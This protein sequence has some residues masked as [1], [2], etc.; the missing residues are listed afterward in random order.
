M[1]LK[2]FRVFFIGL[3][4]V[5]CDK[6]LTTNVQIANY[7]PTMVLEGILQ[8]KQPVKIKLSMSHFTDSV[9]NFQPISEADVRLYKDDSFLEK[10]SY[11]SVGIYSGTHCPEYNSYYRI[12]VEYSNYPKLK[13]ET[14]I[15]DSVI[16]KVNKEK[17]DEGS[18]C[19]I[20]IQ[21]FKYIENY[22]GVSI[23]QKH[24]SC[25]A[26]YNSVYIK[27]PPEIIEFSTTSSKIE[28]TMYFEM[29]DKFN[30]EGNS[31]RGF[32]FFKGSMLNGGNLLF[33]ELG[34]C[35]VNSV[36]IYDMSAE[37][38]SFFKS[39]AVYN[40]YNERVTGIKG[41]FLL[42]PSIYSNVK[43][44]IGI[45]GYVNGYEVEIDTVMRYPCYY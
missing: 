2:F 4:L 5:S 1:S 3:L 28:E 12:E 37:V 16:F 17:K 13:A 29:R 35:D 33:K 45:F 8:V 41:P 40:Y 42:Q 14:H 30:T 15:K 34:Y 24:I 32:V 26:V 21:F 43:N 25:G 20:L 7:K 9:F 36:I 31:T 6:D 22:Y 10:L 27:N 44:G 18:V 11:D 19:N 39:M 38:Y 23:N